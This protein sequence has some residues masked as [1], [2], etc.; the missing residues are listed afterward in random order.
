MNIKNNLKNIMYLM[1]M[2]LVDF[3]L[4]ASSGYASQETINE[5]ENII[6]LSAN[7]KNKEQ[8]IDALF[9][10]NGSKVSE[11]RVND[12]LL[13]RECSPVIADFINQH[14]ELLK[15]DLSGNIFSSRGWAEIS[16]TLL[17]LPHLKK[18]SLGVL[19]LKPKSH[20]S[21]FLQEL[22]AK[23]TLVKLD[24]RNMP[25]K[26]FKL[27][28]EDIAKNMVL[29]TLVLS[30]MKLTLCQFQQ[31]GTLLNNHPSLRKLILGPVNIV[32]QDD[33]STPLEKPETVPG[34]EFI[35]I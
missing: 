15:V 24:V 35:L 19:N 9:Q 11:L 6:N 14:P 32:E 7:I 1:V 8:L 22:L 34:K 29:E 30:D 20:Y 27:F 16:P 13:T 31:L 3:S 2:G 12:N 5:K 23:E 25:R 18:L 10:Y 28:L 17:Q 4:T 33:S 26:Y 21:C